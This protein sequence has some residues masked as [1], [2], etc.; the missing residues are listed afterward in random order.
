[1]WVL[2]VYIQLS[3]EAYHTVTMQEFEFQNTCQAAGT[4]IWEFSG[5]KALWTC[6]K[7]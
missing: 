1:M 4:K 3:N 2:I 6:V 7:K 5:R